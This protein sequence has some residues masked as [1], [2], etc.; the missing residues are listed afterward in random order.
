MAHA[1]GRGDLGLHSSA[2]VGDISAVA[3]ELCVPVSGLRGGVVPQAALLR[4][5]DGGV[6][7]RE[8]QN[9]VAA[10]GKFPWGGGAG[11]VSDRMAPYGAFSC[12]VN[13][14]PMRDAHDNTAWCGFSNEGSHTGCDL[15]TEPPHSGKPGLPSTLSP[16]SLVRAIEVFIRL[17]NGC[18]TQRVHAS[19][20]KSRLS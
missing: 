16:R 14:R 13:S 3:D 6:G 5:V 20:M 17:L 15:S 4:G 19:F 10:A 11:A 7:H 2:A 12:S 18:I 1:M 9:M 8:G